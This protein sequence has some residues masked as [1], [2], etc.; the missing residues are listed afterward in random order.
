MWERFFGFF[1]SLLTS[2]SQEVVTLTI[3]ASHD[4]KSNLGANL[5]YLKE[6]TKLDPW[7]VGKEQ[8]SYALNQE[9][10]IKTPDAD[11][12]RP[13]LLHKLLI[14]RRQDMLVIRKKKSD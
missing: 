5:A 14:Q 8:L 2:S 11:F 4:I 10:A 9:F 6:M 1:H 3:L 12:W 7:S 13:P